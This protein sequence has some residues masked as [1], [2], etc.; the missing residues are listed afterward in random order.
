MRVGVR[1][2]R[3]PQIAPVPSARLE[4]PMTP[5]LRPGQQGLGMGEAVPF[6]ETS[7]P[8][9]PTSVSPAEAP[10]TSSITPAPQ[11]LHL[12]VPAPN[13]CPPR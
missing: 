5:A 6:V 2:E 4:P 3:Q 13:S 12:L 9:H 8:L 11:F 1:Q 10:G 7:A